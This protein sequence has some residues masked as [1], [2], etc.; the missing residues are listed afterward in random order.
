MIFCSAMSM[1]TQAV[2]EPNQQITAGFKETLY[3]GIEFDSIH[4]SRAHPA[5]RQAKGHD[6]KRNRFLLAISNV[7]KGKSLRSLDTYVFESL[8][9]ICVLLK[10]KTS[11]T[12]IGH[13]QQK[14]P[15]ETILKNPWRNGMGFLPSSLH[16]DR[17]PRS[18]L[19]YVEA[20]CT[21]TIRISSIRFFLSIHQSMPR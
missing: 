9:K 14:T 18:N 4:R 1:P 19:F 13:G 20:L 3:R 21:L 17:N 12:K 16:D 6:E 7:R 2:I 8:A 10:E 5:Y 15:V 11:F